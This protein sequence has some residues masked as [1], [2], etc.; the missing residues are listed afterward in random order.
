VRTYVLDA[1]QLIAFLEGR[2]GSERIESLL[3]RAAETKRPVL[4]SVVNWGEVF[5][6][7]WRARGEAV[8]REK[9]KEIGQLP[10]EVVEADAGLALA[11]ATLR[12]R[13]NL[14]YAD[15]FAAAVAEVRG[16]TLVTG[17]R[18]FDCLGT[19]LKIAWV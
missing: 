5:Y 19:T 7:I 18:D 10:I 3:A 6:S 9:L 15:C 16:A 1:S 8:A 2:R 4:M 13:H 17:D 14:P 11:A 12:A